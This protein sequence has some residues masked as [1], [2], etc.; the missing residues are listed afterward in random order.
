MRYQWLASMFSV[1]ALVM[2]FMAYAMPNGYS[3]Q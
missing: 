1:L 2:V 3:W